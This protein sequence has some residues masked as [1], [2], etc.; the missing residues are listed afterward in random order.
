MP[1][2][3]AISE[4]ISNLINSKHDKSK[5][6]VVSN[7]DLIL[8]EIQL[9]FR[10]KSDYNIFKSSKSTI[11]LEN[12]VNNVEKFEKINSILFNKYAI[13][14]FNDVNSIKCIPNLKVLSEN[15]YYIDEK[16]ANLLNDFL[17]VYWEFYE[18]S[19]FSNIDLTLAEK[20]IS[21]E[22][23]NITK[24]LISIKNYISRLDKVLN[25]LDFNLDNLNEFDGEI[26]KN[27]PDLIN[28]NDAT[29]FLEILEKYQKLNLS[30]RSSL[31]YFTEFPENNFIRGIITN[32]K[33]Y[34]SC[35][36]EYNA[37]NQEILKLRDQFKSYG[38]YFNN[39]NEY[40][41]DK[42][43]LIKFSNASY[44]GDGNYL[45]L[46]AK[47][48]EF[49]KFNCSLN[50]YLE[51]CKMNI[52][53]SSDLNLI[54][55]KVNSGLNNIINICDNIGFKFNS[56][57]DLIA[58]K[59]DFE[60]LEEYVKFNKKNTVANE[61]TIKEYALNLFNEL[62]EICYTLI[63]EDNAIDESEL[64]YIIYTI[65]NLNRVINKIGLNLNSLNE[66]NDSFLIIANLEND[67]SS[68]IFTVQTETYLQ[69]EKSVIH[70][71]LDL[72]KN[73]LNSLLGQ[74]IDKPH[75]KDCPID[76]L[77]QSFNNQFKIGFL[78][79]NLESY[80]D[81]TKTFEEILEN[82]EVI[83]QNAINLIDTTNG[84]EFKSKLDKIS[85]ELKSISQ[86]HETQNYSGN[87]LM[88]NNIS[89]YKNSITGEFNRLV[90]NRLFSKEKIAE[91]DIEILLEELKNNIL[92][93]QDY[94]A[95]NNLNN[96]DLNTIIKNNNEIMQSNDRFKSKIDDSTLYNFY[97]TCSQLNIQDID[98]GLINE[99][100]DLSKQL[101]IKEYD[102]FSKFS[103][104]DL[105]EFSKNL[106][107]NIEFS[108][109]V[110]KGKID[111]NFN[112]SLIQLNEL[113]S[114]IENIKTKFKELKLDDSLLNDFSLID[115]AGVNEIKKELSKIE[116]HLKINST[117]VD[118]L[119]E[120]YKIS[121]D[122]LLNLC[123]NHYIEFEKDNHKFNS[124]DF[125]FNLEG[126][127]YDFNKYE[128]LYEIEKEIYSHGDLIKNNLNSIWNG[129]LTDLEIVKN[130][131]KIDEE[132]TR[133]YSR[134]I[135]TNVTLNNLSEVSTGDLSILNDL[136]NLGDQELK[137]RYLLS[138]KNKDKLISEIN[139][140]NNVDK[141][142]LN[143]ILVIFVNINKIYKSDE[144][145]D[146]ITLLEYNIKHADSIRLIKEYENNLRYHSIVYYKFFN[147]RKF[148]MPIEEVIT[149]LEN[150]FKF[151]ELI[152]LQIINERY[153]D[154]IKSN[155]NDFIGYV[156]KL[157]EL[158]SEIL[159]STSV[160]YDNKNITFN[161]I[162][163]NSTKLDDANLVLMD[164]KTLRNS[165]D[166]N[167]ITYFDHVYIVDDNTLTGEDK[168]HLFLI[169]KNRISMLK[170]MEG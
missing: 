152:D 26:I 160:Y 151:T 146:C 76:K 12:L 135:Y 24:K 100:L 51:R 34:I 111:N 88:I 133:Q 11:Q 60:I 86:M 77:S 130:K 66:I 36:D 145:S 104:N 2:N 15:L 110:D 155:F 58:H 166:S 78:K 27:N 45:I 67:T 62:K 39:L 164:L 163:E 81:S 30:N 138:Y 107:N 106:E 16:N 128:E 150:H 19:N 94:I 41:E 68:N 69:N 93:V 5:I 125:L 121:L 7:N 53:F 109:Y 103:L 18:V 102:E 167:Y 74:L 47:I 48:K 161:E 140:L 13:K 43:Q 57:S 112:V 35:Q 21:S 71:D 14:L 89:S 22:V 127:E 83:I 162:K 122:M 129:P 82:Y 99:I 31:N 147:S 42:D 79:S 143:S 154:D 8:D 85:N 105:I 70:N 75:L 95:A 119:I 113:D 73:S 141:D 28:S 61:E 52:K 149:R 6:L 148:D 65:S 46:N 124:S 116:E 29:H 25:L 37:L 132:F 17:K 90:Q 136:K 156:E 170:L 137:S 23:N 20:D 59:S 4:K 157:D 139:R 40:Y 38:L 142:D 64:D 55:L 32:F 126:I 49:L 56:F 169:S 3:S 63:N 98:Y 84:L 168:L 9:E 10:V 44:L 123:K 91:C 33:G 134:G 117:N 101:N 96:S 159:E 80:L 50:D 158:T 92:I 72:L 115:I 108:E 153:L 120:N 87:Q 54:Y 114:K 131:I 144:I 165:F 1:N 118:E 97:D